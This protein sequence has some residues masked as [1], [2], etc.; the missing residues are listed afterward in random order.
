MPL[1]K[2]LLDRGLIDSSFAAD[3]FVNVDSE[4]LVSPAMT[5]AEVVSS[6]QHSAEADNPSTEDVSEDDC[7]DEVPLVSH[8][9]ASNCLQKLR[10]FVVQRDG[11]SDL[12]DQIVKLE[13]KIDSF[14]VKHR[15][16][17]TLESYI[18]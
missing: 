14:A 5:V 15:Y 2:G 1:V 8:Y 16:Q 13:K 12:L 18:F 10:Y 7:G 4:L 17:V 9:E 6:L 11:N 3:D